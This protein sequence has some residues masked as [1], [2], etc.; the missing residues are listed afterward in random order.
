ME[1]WVVSRYSRARALRLARF[2][3]GFGVESHGR[4]GVVDVVRDAAG[5]LAQ[6]AQPLLLHDR[7]LGLAQIV[8]GLLQRVVIC[9]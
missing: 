6:R 7:L 3:A 2:R 5:H 4:N 1:R 8:I 9:A